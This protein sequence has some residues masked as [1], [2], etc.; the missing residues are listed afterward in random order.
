VIDSLLFAV[1]EVILASNF[2]WDSRTMDVMPDGHPR[3]ITANWFLAIHQEQERG[4]MMNALDEY[5]AFTLTMTR[6]LAQVPVDKAGTAILA[7]LDVRTLAKE[8]GFNARAQQL[9]TFLHMNWAVIGRANELLLEMYAA[10]YVVNGFCEPA[11]WENTTVPKLVGGEWF[12]AEAAQA[13][14][15]ITAEIRFADARRLQPITTFS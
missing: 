12:S 8:T 14:A 3:P 2:G 1:K 5:Y 13:N 11:H 4:D 15:G 9:K 10:E 7:N 6:M